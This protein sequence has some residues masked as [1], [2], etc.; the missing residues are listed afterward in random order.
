MKKSTN[1]IVIP[2][3]DDLQVTQAGIQNLLKILDYPVSS[4]GQAL[5]RALLARNDKKVI[6]KQS[7]SPGL[8]LWSI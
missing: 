2:V 3:V 8:R 6:M 5:R 4:T 7:Y 1:K